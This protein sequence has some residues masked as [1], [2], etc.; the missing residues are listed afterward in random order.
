MAVPRSKTDTIVPKDV[1]FIPAGY[2]VY[3]HILEAIG[4]KQ[5]LAV[6]LASVYRPPPLQIW[7][8]LVARY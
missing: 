1:L 6:V 7:R 8:V 3:C 4:Y 5:K 2:G